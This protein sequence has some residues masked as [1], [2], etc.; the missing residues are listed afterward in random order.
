MI[1]M[2]LTI[3]KSEESTKLY[4]Q[5]VD[6]LKENPNSIKTISRLERTLGLL[7]A[8]ISMVYHAL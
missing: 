6:L 4:N 1:D 7:V 5:L 8:F 3:E 2:E